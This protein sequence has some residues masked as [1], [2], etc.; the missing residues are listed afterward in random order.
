MGDLLRRR[1]FGAVRQFAYQFGTRG[2]WAPVSAYNLDRRS[3]GGGVLVVTGTHFLDRMLHWFGYPVRMHLVDDSRGGPEANAAA[4]FVFESDGGLVRGWA[5][6]SKT[7]ALEAGLVIDTDAGMVVLRERPD[8][9]IIV[10]PSR[11]EA[12]ETVVRAR[13]SEEGGSPGSHEFLLQLEDFAAACRGEH[14]PMVPGEVGL[15]SLR[16]LEQLYACRSPLADDW[17][18]GTTLDRRTP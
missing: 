18:E 14:P 7:V 2:G 13:G 10:R 3:S 11:D 1:Y 16:L 5:R 4:C 12:M 15:K 9:P 8:A 6:F 17:Y